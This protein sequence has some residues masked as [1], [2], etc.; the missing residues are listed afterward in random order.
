MAVIKMG[1]L[2]SAQNKTA[3]L[4]VLEVAYS[5]LIKFVKNNKEN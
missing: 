5:F 2:K 3:Y 1:S 4:K